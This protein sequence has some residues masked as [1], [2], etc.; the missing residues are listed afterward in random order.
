MQCF[1]YALPDAE[2]VGM[3]ASDASWL[4]QEIGNFL[5]MS[6]FSSMCCLICL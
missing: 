2:M 3:V 1:G 4:G 6:T 5:S